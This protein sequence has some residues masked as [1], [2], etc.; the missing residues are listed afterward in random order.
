[1]AA[2][3]APPAS[4][5]IIVNPVAGLGGPAGL[6]GSDGFAVQQEAR[7]R[8]SRPRSGERA[9]AA[10]AVLAAAHPGLEVLCP[11]GELGE[12]AVT[13]AGLRAVVVA[14]TSGWTATG[15]DTTRAASA[16][17]AAGASLIL[18][19]G[20]DG[21]ARD[22][23]RGLPPLVSALGIPAGVKMY[24]SCFAVS[25][26]VAGT[27]AADWVTQGPSPTTQAEVLDLDEDALRA[28]R[29]DPRLFGHLAIPAA[30]GRTQARKSS[31]P[32]GEA[33]AVHRA[34]VG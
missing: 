34:A 13:S 32:A 9:G 3:P 15:D 8:G 31:T 10:L 26:A 20:G 11:P 4:V 28:G 29:A 7:A 14:P 30:R 6:V 17:A 12:D 21:T 22:V 25:P 18:F 16:L 5:G 33:D 19:A 23:V 1:M 27:M 24:S 2:R